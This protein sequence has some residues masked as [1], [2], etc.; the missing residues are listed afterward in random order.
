MIKF[1][2]RLANQTSIALLICC[3]LTNPASAKSIYEAQNGDT[4]NATISS[5]DL[6]RIEVSGQKI[7]KNFKNKQW[8]CEWSVDKPKLQMTWE[9][10]FQSFYFVAPW[11][12]GRK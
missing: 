3:S 1:L 4:I 10:L 8:N 7:I 6:T 12:R 2:T 9:C 5:T 11:P